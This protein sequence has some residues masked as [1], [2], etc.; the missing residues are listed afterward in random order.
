VD[1]QNL[2]TPVISSQALQG[3]V[4]VV[5]GSSR[6]IGQAIAIAMAQAGAK[7]V[8]TYV[9]R[10]Q[11]AEEVARQI[12][13]TGAQVLV[14]GVDISQREQVERLFSKTLEAFG[15]LDVL[16]N[17]AAAFHPKVPLLELSE[18]DW[19]RVMGVNLKGT[20]LCCQV[21]ARHM[22]QQGSGTIINISSTGAYE[23]F[24]NM[25][26]YSSSKGGVNALTRALAVELAPYGI[27]V[28]GIAPGHIDTEANI[29]FLAEVPG[30]DEKTFRRIPLARLGRT[31][32][33]ATMAVFLASDGVGYMI[34]QTVLVEGGLTIWQGPVD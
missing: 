7:V 30:R 26:A 6:G 21:A 28:N 34:G 27:R 20:F 18:A 2:A 25:G 5:T 16:V 11:E 15:R 29:K 24:S 33:I 14:V 4:A 31:E 17:N 1:N 9:S 8:V 3:R 32:E 19:D 10:R 13:A 12:E 22:I 23:V